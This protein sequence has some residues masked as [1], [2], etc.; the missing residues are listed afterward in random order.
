MDLGFGNVLGGKSPL[1]WGI[2]KL[3]GGLAGWGLGEA[4]AWGDTLAAAGKLPGGMPG[5]PGGTGG[6][7]LSGA[8]G[9]IPGMKSLMPHNLGPTALQPSP[10]STSMADPNGSVHGSSQGAAPGPV[11]YDQSINVSG[12]TM[13]D[14]HQLV[15]PMQAQM[16]ANTA[17]RASTGVITTGPGG[18]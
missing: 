1:D 13:V 15:P 12:N 2:V 8:F 14:P 11:T 5:M 6:S 9:A 3:L 16:N 7:I 10:V 18:G 4:N 17:S